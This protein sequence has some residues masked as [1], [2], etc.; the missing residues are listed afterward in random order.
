MEIHCVADA[1]LPGI[2]ILNSR[3]T[4]DH[5]AYQIHFFKKPVIQLGWFLVK[6]DG[7]DH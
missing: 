4:V 3:R 7:K 6:E 1:G 2:P 5:F